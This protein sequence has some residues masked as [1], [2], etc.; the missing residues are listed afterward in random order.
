MKLKIGFFFTAVFSL[1]F[2][3]VEAQS[4]SKYGEDSVTCVTNFSLYRDAY[5]K[6]NYEEAY[7][8]WKSVL[9]TCP[10]SSK[11][12]FI[13]GPIILDSKIKNA[14]A[15]SA[16]CEQYI[17]ELF[18]LFKKRMEI[19][20]EDEAYCRGQIGFNTMRYRAKGYEN[21][22]E[23]LRFAVTHGGTATPPQVMNMYFLTAERYMK[24]KALSSEIVI[25]AYD[26]IT[27]VLDESVDMSESA[28]DKSMKK[29]YDL[30]DSLEQ[31]V[32]D[33]LTYSVTYEDLA[34][35]SARAFSRYNSFLKVSKNIDNGFSKYANCEDLVNI[36]GKKLESANDEKTLRQIIK[37]FNKK[38]CTENDIYIAAVKEL[39]RLAPTAQTA[40]YMGVNS[41][42]DQQY[43]EAINYFNEALSMYTKESDTIQAYIMLGETCLSLKQ[44]SQAREYAYKV[45][46]KNPTNGK[47]YI[48]IGKAYE[49]SVFS[50]D[51]PGAANWAAADK[52]A[53]AMRVTAGFKDSDP[54]QKKVYEDAQRN[55]SSV[56]ARFPKSETYFQRGFQKGQ[57]YKV[58]GWINE[59]TT[60]R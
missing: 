11:N 10:K 45:I 40:F 19:Y 37:L 50:T 26:E 13:N 1:I 33:S 38:A 34:K 20:P 44:Y 7:P 8:Y 52:Y 58:E 29:I 48:L 5:K 54:K 6:K 25:N 41:Y 2:V 30:R 60:V 4:V 57:S 56:S 16:K 18:D 42:K 59:T 15:D 12:I 51:I 21:A 14:K 24:N 23:D 46:R 9:E 3:N 31:G 27:E 49:L 43:Q 36:F 53:K 32:Y 28:L 35:D 55:L 39:H 47:A 22:Y 17:D